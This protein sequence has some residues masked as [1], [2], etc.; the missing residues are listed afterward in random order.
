MLLEPAG[1]ELP[2]ALDIDPAETAAVDYLDA[3]SALLLL[4][5]SR[6]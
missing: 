5:R 6:G 1:L 2:R 3:R 4:R